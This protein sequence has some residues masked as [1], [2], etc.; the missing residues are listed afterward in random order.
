M[1]V[2]RSEAFITKGFSDWKDG[3]IAF[4]NHEVSSY[5]KEA[6]HIIVVIPSSCPDVGAMLSRQYA[7]EMRNNCKCFLKI[8][9]P[10]QYL[11]WQGIA[12]WGDGNDT[13]TNF[14][15][16]LKLQAG[17]NQKLVSWLSQKTNNYTSHESQN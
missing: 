1:S 10:T 8:M 6:L 11:A 5:H 17:D 13:D 12:L 4:K 2:G 9:A 16:L 15:Q 7:D 3:T 14:I